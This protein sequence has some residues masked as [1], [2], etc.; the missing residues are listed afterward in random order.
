MWQGISGGP[1][2]PER[3]AG[4]EAELGPEVGPLAVGDR[5]PARA[6]WGPTSWVREGSYHRAGALPRGHS[7]LYDAN[8]ISLPRGR[9]GVFAEL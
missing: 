4:S 8:I 7:P 5:R 1:L 6:G 9:P 3:L 2:C